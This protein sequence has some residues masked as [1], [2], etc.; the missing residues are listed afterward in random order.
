MCVG[1]KGVWCKWV[2]YELP[3]LFNSLCLQPKQS[4]S[5]EEIIEESCRYKPLEAKH[6]EA[7][8]WMLR[9]GKEDSRGTG[10]STDSLCY[11]G[12]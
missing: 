2:R 9:T 10:Q 12:L 11:N 7:G 6:P 5:S 4:S 1:D 3:S 8:G